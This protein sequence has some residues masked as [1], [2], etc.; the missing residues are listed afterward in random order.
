MPS[1][2]TGSSLRGISTHI[3]GRHAF[4]HERVLE[5]I[6]RETVL[7]DGVTFRKSDLAHRL[8]CQER[9]LNM[10][11]AR[12]RRDGLITVEAQHDENG[13][14]LANNYRATQSGIDWAQRLKE[15]A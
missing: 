13:G 10:A 2:G 1:A 14:Q 9:T 8:G 7:R 15:R 6:A 3:N 4:V 12:L 5:L 11:I